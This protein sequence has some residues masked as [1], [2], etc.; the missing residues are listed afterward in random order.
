MARTLSNKLFQSVGHQNDIN[1]TQNSQYRFE[2]GFSR[3][4]KYYLN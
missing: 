1:D 3:R 4:K 2:S